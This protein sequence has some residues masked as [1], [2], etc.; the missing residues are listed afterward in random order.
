MV[1]ERANSG[2]LPMACQRMITI[3]R[4][5]Y[6]RNFLARWFEMRCNRED[7]GARQVGDLGLFAS[8]AANFIYSDLGPGVR[9]PMVRRVV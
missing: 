1:I 4:E 3:A 6:T 9:T 8:N 2:L 5:W 7:G